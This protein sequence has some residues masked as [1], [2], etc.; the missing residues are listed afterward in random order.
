[1]APRIP[2]FT[3]VQQLT[4]NQCSFIYYCHVLP[5]NYSHIVVYTTE[6]HL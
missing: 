2:S 4:Q 3:Q 5:H 6:F 1:M